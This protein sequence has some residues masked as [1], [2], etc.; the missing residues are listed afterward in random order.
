MEPTR[1]KIMS[2]KVL[3]C[4]FLLKA[5]IWG[6]LHLI[7]SKKGFIS[8]TYI[9]GRHF[10][11][12]TFITQKHQSLE[13]LVH[14]Q[15]PFREHLS[16]NGLKWLCCSTWLGP[17]SFSIKMVLMLRT[18]SLQKASN[19]EAIC[20]YQKRVLT[21]DTQIFS[22]LFWISTSGQHT[23]Q[24][25]KLS[26]I[27]LGNKFETTSQPN[28]LSVIPPCLTHLIPNVLRSPVLVGDIPCP[29]LLKSSVNTPISTCDRA[30]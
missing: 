2:N 9:K 29:L 28:H 25:Q 19:F 26:N 27:M 22:S 7:Q 24:V 18:F 15:H 21:N 10:C 16:E 5:P 8:C 1:T 13:C 14:T 3:D 17:Y 12:T 30:F 6:G 4:F 23:P 20:F 11:T